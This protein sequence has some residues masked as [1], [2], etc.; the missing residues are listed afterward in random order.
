MGLFRRRRVPPDAVEVLAAYARTD[1]N[2]WGFMRPAPYEEH[3][4]GQ[5][6]RERVAWAADLDD[7]L[8]EA[9]GWASVGAADLFL[10]VFG[11]DDEEMPPAVH[12]TVRRGLSFKRSLGMWECSLSGHE[13]AYRQRHA[14]GE[15]WLE[16]QLPPSRDAVEIEPLAPGSDRLLATLTDEPGAKALYAVRRADG[17]YVVQ[18]DYDDDGTRRREERGAGFDDLYDLYA[19][20]GGSSVVPSAWTDPVFARFQPYPQPLEG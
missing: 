18:L 6:A 20:L 9:G 12:A 2:D 15:V 16:R 3:L 1:R 10:R 11:V 17:A 13:S 8:A 5:S 7:D 19:A 14:P 4:R